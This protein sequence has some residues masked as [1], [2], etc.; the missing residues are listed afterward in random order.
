ME[1]WK[2]IKDFENYWVSSE[3]RIWSEK[4]NKFL[5]PWA[6][7]EGYLQVGLWRNGKRYWHS[8]HRLVAE[9]F[10]E[11]RENKPEVD[12]INRDTKDNR[13]ENLR[14]TDRHEQLKNRDLANFKYKHQKAQGTPIIE[15]INDEV[16]IGYPALRAV[17][18]INERALSKHV[19]KGKVEFIC[20]G[21]TFICRDNVLQ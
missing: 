19:S 10:I 18:G 13:V 3:G 8:I 17:P 5:K 12:H 4:R 16:L 11:N 9:A 6:N 20:K 7:T 1:L 2:E 15:K 21:R 14:W